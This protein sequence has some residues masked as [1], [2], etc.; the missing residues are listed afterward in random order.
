MFDSYP[1]DTVMNVWHR[2]R[3]PLTFVFGAEMFIFAIAK[4]VQTVAERVSRF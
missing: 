1:K 3:F 4:T 2:F